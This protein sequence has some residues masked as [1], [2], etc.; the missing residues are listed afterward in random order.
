MDQF[1]ALTKSMANDRIAAAQYR[2]LLA[3]SP[4]GIVAVDGGGIIQLV[5]HTAEVL[6]GYSSDELVGR[7][8]EVLVP[9]RV[10]EIHA[11]ERNEYCKSPWSRPMGMG[12]ELTGRRRDGSELPVEISLAHVRVGSETTV[13]SFITDIRNRTET[14]ALQREAQRI[15]AVG[16]LAGRV[17]DEFNQLLD[18]LSRQS[19]VAMQ[20]CQD[21]PVLRSSVE[22]MSAASAQA[23]LISRKLLAFSRGMRNQPEWFEPNQRLSEMR[24]V[25]NDALG[26]GVELDLLP[27]EDVGE[28]LGDPL[29]FG[30]VIL[31][32]VQNAADAMPR[33]GRA[34]IETAAVDVGED[35]VH[36]HL[37]LSAGPH[38]LVKV[39]DTGIGMTPDVQSRIFEPFCTTKAGHAGLGLAAVYGI[40]R[41]AG[42][43]IA[44][45][46]QPGR[47][48]AFHLMFPRIW[49]M[50]QETDGER[51][52]S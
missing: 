24:H 10:R 25:L 9:E 14:E 6:F 34:A 41:D 27:G 38:L 22:A 4:H 26:E 11:E 43:S 45:S 17:A 23:Q 46:T 35:F 28:I 19:C 48:T 44:A 42:G 50:G 52:E 20:R 39:T 7:S 21:D 18:V 40:V 30:E 12:I 1:S 15:E 33:G 49:R 16:R 29:Q 31:N 36:G 47:G 13:F 5:N 2:A 3:S 8:I 37:P 32:L 51:P